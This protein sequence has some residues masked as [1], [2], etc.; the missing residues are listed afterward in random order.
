MGV[1]ITNRTYTELFTTGTTNWLLGNVGEWQ[2]LVLKCEASVEFKAT[3]GETVT[4]TASEK[5]FTLNNGKKWSDYGFDVGNV[6]R[7]RFYHWADSLFEG[8]LYGEFTISGLYDNVMEV[9]A[10]TNWYTNPELTVIHAPIRTDTYPNEKGNSYVRDVTFYTVIEPEGLRFTYSHIPNSESDGGQLMSV[11][12]GTETTFVQPNVKGQTVGIFIPMEAIGMQSGM[13]IKSAEVKRLG[14]KAGSLNIYEYEIKVTYLISSFFQ[15]ITNLEERT[16]PEYLTGDGSLTDNFRFLFYPKWNNPNSLIQ[17]NPSYTERLGNTGWFN[18]NFNQLVNEFSIQDLKYFDENGNPVD[19]LDYFASTK[20][21]A[22]ITGV[23]N[24][25]NNTECGFGFMWV[26]KYEEDYKNKL[27]PYYRNTFINTGRTTDGYKVGTF[28]PEVNVGGGLGQA[29]METRNVKFTNLGNGQVAFEALFTPTA[30]FSV[31]FDNKEAEDRKYIIWLS[32]ADQTLIRNFSDRVSL[33]ADLNTMIKTVPPAGPYPFINLAFLEHPYESDAT[34]VEE[35][36]GFVQDDV[37]CRIPLQINPSTTQVLKFRFGVEIYKASTNERRILEKFDVDT[38]QFYTDANG[39]P[40]YNLNAI[41][42]FKL[43]DGNNKNWV[44]LVRE[45]ILDATNQIGYMAFYAFKI[46]WED[47]IAMANMPNDF[48]SATE[49]NNGFN[50]DWFHYLDTA[51]WRVNFFTEIEAIVDTVLLQYRNRWKMT[52]KDYDQNSRIGTKHSYFRHSDDTFLNIGT[53]PET[54]KPLGVI[55]SNEPTRLE[56]EYE[57]LDGGIWEEGNVYATATIE[58]DKGAG[59]MQMRQ[60]SSVWGSEADNPL[61]PL[62][63]QDHLTIVIDGTQKVLTT[64]C[65]IDPDLLEDAQ[66]YRIT[67]RV[68]C[69]KDGGVVIFGKYEGRYERR[70]E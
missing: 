51:G 53:D 8:W 60:I 46:R 40:Q 22:I 33:L 30:T 45:P 61:I 69:Y 19:A 28:Y 41:R 64:L 63:G 27:T 54:Q 37:L 48:F 17:N 24:V 38:G 34:G 25:T 2:T 13:S 14:F 7:V 16:I 62:P 6:I 32:V 20:V 55:L 52:F 18:E 43:Q 70:Y 21:T 36:E 23:P 47:W 57:I 5:T 59:F 58:V 15:E 29:W 67:G 44:K 35:Y 10:M 66:R 68:G 3:Q 31:L 65:L 12:D 56:I 9:V 39:V 1:K 11:I 42:G 50:N 26:P 4:T 49:L